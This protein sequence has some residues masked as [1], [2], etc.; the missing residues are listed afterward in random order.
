MQGKYMNIVLTG[1]MGTGKTAIG[2][3]LSIKLGY[4]Y[5]DTDTIIESDQRMSI[6]DIFS[7]HGEPFFRDIETCV[8]IRVSNLD[9]HII[10]TG[11]GAVLRE[12]NISVLRKNGIIIN[13][14]ASPETILERIK[15]NT[16]RPLLNKPDPMSE[17]RKLLESRESYY[18]DSDFR[19][20]TDN[21]TKDEIADKII[22]FLEQRTK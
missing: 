8:I 12:Q 3:K 22:L 1:F 7:K 4:I 5:I 6:K 19:V 10:S 17:I 18:A 11:G 13:L 2:K 15:H 16:N 20:N 21:L 14:Y 9:D